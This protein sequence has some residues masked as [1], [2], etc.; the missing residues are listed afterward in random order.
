MDLVAL[1]DAIVA[2]DI[3]AQAV[4]AAA[5]SRAQ[6]VTPLNA[7]VRIDADGAME[8][9]RAADQRRAAG[10]PLG[11]LHGVPLAHKD[12]FYRAGRITGCGSKIRG[13]FVAET[14]CDLLTRLDDAG[15]IE[16][17]QLHMAEF[18][19]GPTGHNAHLGRCR[20][21]W[22]ADAI[23]GG[24][25]SGSGAAV[26]ARVVAGALGS[27]TGGSVRLPAH[28]CGVVGLKPTHG[29]LTQ[30]DMMPLSE[31]LDTAGPLARSSRS[32]ARLMDVLTGDAV[33]EAALRSDL[34]GMRVGILDADD[35]GECDKPVLNAL[36]EAAHTLA[37]LGAQVVPVRLPD[38][39]HYAAMAAL[40]W[41][42][43]AAAL[44]LPTLRDHADDYG[45]QVRNRLMHGLSMPATHYV[46]ARRL[47][48]CD[49]AAFLSGP[50]AG[51]DAIAL[52]TCRMVTPMAHD[53]DADAGAAMD[54]VIGGLSALTR[55]FSYLGV[56]GLVT[57]MGFDSRGLPMGLQLIGAPRAEA[58]LC[59]IGH[60]YE[61]ATNWLARPLPLL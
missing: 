30:A 34:R 8:A 44:H 4:T 16:I 10:A 32:V 59:A 11:L 38:L 56:P 18:A 9:A 29:R 7:F 5:L 3:T 14:T 48:S 57:P 15:A 17:G 50:M 35:L 46:Q 26:A 55:G 43:E 49:L 22:L 23:T 37:D 19:M 40:V 2:G 54:T 25:S 60:A 28:F 31:S 42:P 12:M 1:A 52:P 24:S 39:A 20:N 33:H 27:D 13:D 21:P 45:P 58:T 47:R 53:A 61:S 41:A 51:L 6:A 36:T